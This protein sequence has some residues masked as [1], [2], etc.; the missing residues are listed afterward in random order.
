MIG[1]V[2]LVVR[3]VYSVIRLASRAVGCLSA[4]DLHL[5]LPLRFPQASLLPGVPRQPV[6]LNGRLEDRSLCNRKSNVYGCAGRIEGGEEEE[7]KE[8]KKEEEK[9][10]EEKE[11]QI[12][13]LLHG[14]DTSTKS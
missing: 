6:L 14:L 8:E 3:H 10:E 4:A 1:I 12:Y 7:K 13:W 11:E 5:K 9:E 2:V